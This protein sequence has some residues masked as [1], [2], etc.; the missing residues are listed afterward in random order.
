MTKVQGNQAPGLRLRLDRRGVGLGAFSPLAWIGAQATKIKLSTGIRQIPGRSPIST[1]M[2]T[3]TMDAL[4]RAASSLGLPNGGLVVRR[5]GTVGPAAETLTW[6]RNYVT[7]VRQIFKR[8]GAAFEFDG[9]MDPLGT[10]SAIQGKPLKSILQHATSPHLRGRA[11][12]GG[13][14]EQAGELLVTASC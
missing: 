8:E 5:A 3:V 9:V 1:A 7:I 6:V 2:A 4:S 10:G 12:A 14:K 11:G 13:A